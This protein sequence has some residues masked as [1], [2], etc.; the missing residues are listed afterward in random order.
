MTVQDIIEYVEEND[1]KFIRLAFC[2]ILGVQ[3]NISIMP[4]K[5]KRAFDKG[6]SVVGSQISGFCDITNPDVRL[7]PD[8]ST[9]TTLPWRPN[10]GQVIKMLCSI[11]NSDGT[12]FAQ[13]SRKILKDVISKIKANGYRCS[14][15]SECE[16][17]LFKTD[18]HG[19]ATQIP[20]DNGSYLDINPR[21]KGENIRRDICMTMETVGLTPEASYHENGPGQNQIDFSFSKALNAADNL[22]N[23][24]SVV[25]S[26]SA[27]NG[28]YASFDPKPLPYSSGSSLHINLSLEKDGENIFKIDGKHTA[29]A[30]SFVAGV[31]DKAREITLFLNPTASSYE[32]FGK[33]EAPKYVSWSHRNSSQLVRIPI[34]H[35][36]EKMRM[37]VRSPDPLA[38]PYLAFALIIGA[39]M[40]GI[41]NKLK[42]CEPVD[43]DLYSAP[44]SIT[45]KLVQLPKKISEAIQLTEE[46]EF[47]SS[48]IGESAKIAFI[49]VIKDSL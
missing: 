4:N 22:I 2:D 6:V 33:F 26:V 35:G 23:F 36:D 42:L 38:N 9:M 28:L 44:S 25:A 13:D 37:E 39:G 18:E 24:K 10:P 29:L 5:L 11:N 49:N 27:R 46:S 8:P 48:I 21:D 16:F 7:V 34:T 12:P 47:V 30:N 43:I 3:K 31:L 40:Y 17:Y 32:R 41:E 14:V 45:E 1:V 20:L 15:G 19:Q